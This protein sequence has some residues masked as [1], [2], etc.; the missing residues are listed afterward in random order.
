MENV[1]AVVDTNAQ[2][3]VYIHNFHITHYAAASSRIGG[4]SRARPRRCFIQ[5]IPRVHIL[6]P[7]AGYGGIVRLHRVCSH[8]ER[9]DN[10]LIVATRQV[11]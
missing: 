6:G 2:R 3:I 10:F 11:Y 9:R 4:S 7:L 5:Q 1:C 8:G